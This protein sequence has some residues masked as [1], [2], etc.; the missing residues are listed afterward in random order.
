MTLGQGNDY[1]LPVIVTWADGQPLN[2]EN[3]SVVEFAFAD[4]V[5]TWYAPPDDTGTVEYSDGKFYVPLSQQET[6]KLQG[7]IVYQV[8]VKDTDGRVRKSRPYH[9]SVS[10]SITTTVL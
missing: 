2:I 8:R 3:C 9:A 7:T 4:I 1:L 5:K 6:F 10:E